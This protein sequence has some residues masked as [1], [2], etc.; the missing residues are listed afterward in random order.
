MFST[1]P[2]SA[3]SRFG[4]NVP[5][6]RNGWEY[7]VPATLDGVSIAFAFLA[8]RAVRRGKAPD[9]CYRVV[10][11]AAGASASINFSYE[12]GQS[13]NLLAAATSAC[14]AR[15]RLGGTHDHRSLWYELLRLERRPMSEV[16]TIGSTSRLVEPVAVGAAALGVV[17]WFL[18]LTWFPYAA[19]GY[20][21][22]VVLASIAATRGR[23]VIGPDGI[24]A[25]YVIRRRHVPW[26]DV[27]HLYVEGG[28]L[29]RYVQVQRP[30]GKR[31]ALPA[32]RTARFVRSARFDAAVA[33]L[34]R[35]STAQVP[36]GPRVLESGRPRVLYIIAV[37]AILAG[38]LTVDRPW[39][40]LSRDIFVA[41]PDPCALLAHGPASS[42]GLS[43][44]STPTLRTF[45]E[46]RLGAYCQ[47]TGD[48]QR[49][50]ELVTVLEPRI[51]LMSGTGQAQADMH[52]WPW[53][54]DPEGLQRTT[55]LDLGDAGR[56]ETF[57]EAVF[58]MFRR[59]NMIVE[60]LYTTPGQSPYTDTVAIA[61]DVATQ[62]GELS[63][64]R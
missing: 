20:A 45:S 30:D 55:N 26:P 59:S 37:F 64:G 1:A 24:Q 7:L 57:D 53:H 2:L 61:R 11:G 13:G 36:A 33:L 48:D 32:M 50:L 49:S 19:W 18:D 5:G 46:G 58:V 15:V 25:R 14:S 62:L 60:L 63:E 42:L 17:G 40:W 4:L 12:Y 51:G 27:W 16:L 35:S 3:W 43:G 9:R 54:F 56:I 10:W 29:Q 44:P 8:F 23:V 22:L 39:Y 34:D 31:F 52:D 6:W 47:W 21:A 41:T 28:L 38:S